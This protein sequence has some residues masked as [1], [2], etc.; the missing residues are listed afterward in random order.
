MCFRGQ[1]LNYTLHNNF[2][3]KTQPQK[4]ILVYTRSPANTWGTEPTSERTLYYDW[5]QEACLFDSTHPIKLYAEKGRTES[6]IRV[7]FLGNKQVCTYM[8]DLTN[9]FYYCH[10]HSSFI[11]MAMD[12]SPLSFIR[13]PRMLE[14]AHNQD[15]PLR[16]E[17]NSDSS[18]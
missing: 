11:L 8:V 12:F 14:G 1:S 6:R 2:Y 18:K 16:K 9:S 15:D 3:H 5:N 13:L 10:H 4:I 17:G 7:W